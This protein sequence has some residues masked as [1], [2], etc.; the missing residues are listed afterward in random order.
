MSTLLDGGDGTTHDHLKSVKWCLEER[1]SLDYRRG[2]VERI[3][4][5]FDY[6]HKLKNAGAGL[7]RSML[8]DF[9]FTQN[10]EKMDCD[11]HCNHVGQSDLTVGDI[12]LS[13]KTTE[14]GN[15][16]ALNWSKNPSTQQP[17]PH[18]FD[19]DILI[20]VMRS[21]DWYK[22]KK[23]PDDGFIGA[24]MYLIP[25]SVANHVVVFTTNNKSNSIIKKKYVFQLLKYS[26]TNE[27]YIPFPNL[28]EVKSNYYFDLTKAFSH[29]KKDDRVYS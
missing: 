22:R 10:L 19:T 23:A 9:I 6:V 15:D 21:G 25:A 4:A 13:F 26:A 8:V 27:L 29:Q 14:K 11:I 20:Y 17:M 12:P 24:G 16:L 5:V 1:M 28:T 3:S 2:F 18:R 7:I